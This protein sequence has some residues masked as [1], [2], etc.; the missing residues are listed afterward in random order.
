MGEG[1]DAD[2]TRQTRLLGESRLPYLWGPM[3]GAALFGRRM[4]WRVETVVALQD[5]TATARTITLKV[6]GWP[7]HIAGQHTDVRL[8]ASDGY[9]AVRSYSIASAPSSNGRIELT[10]ERL[11]DGEV[12][13]D[14]T[15]EVAV[16]D[17]RALR[18]PI[19]GW[20]VWRPRQ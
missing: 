1:L 4:I 20:F 19:R 16:D 9:S 12:S 18:G 3:A 15:E 7:G 17:R 8:T 6:P 5:E 10:V 11:S 13:P 14:L 2:V